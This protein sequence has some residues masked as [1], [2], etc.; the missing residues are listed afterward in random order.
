[1]DT[2][3]IEM[4]TLEE[5]RTKPLAEKIPILEQIAHRTRKHVVR[6]VYEA[7]SG[8]IGGS[9]SATE[10]LT[11]LYFHTMHYDP[12][13]PKWPDRDRFVLS[14]GHAAPALYA[15]MAQAGFFDESELCTLRQVG[16]RLQGH[17]VRGTLPGIEASTGSLGQGLSIANGMALGA[18]VDGDDYRVYAIIGDGESDCGQI[19]EAAMAA[20]HFELDNLVVTL[21]RNE[22]QIDGE[23]E[24]VMR[25]EPL[26][27]KW[28]AFGWEVFEIDGHDILSLIETYDRAIAVRKKPSL[29]ISHTTKGKGVSFMEHNLKF[30]GAPPS[31][32]EYECAM[33]ELSECEESG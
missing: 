18:R 31:G 9:L 16:S 1:M 5:L 20:A 6:M 11:V 28:R 24:D 30:H 2:L 25:L 17:P 15:I 26:A 32:E 8:H 19:W 12:A 4:W 14:K 3:G 21:D 27:D 7:Q 13:R 10:A 29:I 22:Q 23:T 33:D